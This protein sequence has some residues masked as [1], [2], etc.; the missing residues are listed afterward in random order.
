MLLAAAL[1]SAGLRATS[2]DSWRT[3]PVW[4]DGLSEKCEYEA[5]R[6]IY[7][8]Q[9]VYLAI[10]YSD[11]EVAD[12]RLTVK[13]EKNAGLEVIKHHWSEIIPTE[14]Y[15]YRFSTMSY[16]SAKDLSAFKLTVGTQE[17]CGASFK[18]IW[19]EGDRLRWFESVYFPGAGRREGECE[20]GETAT[21]AD[22]LTLVLRDYPF[23]APRDLKLHVIPSQ[24]DTHRV[25]FDPVARV[26]RH[27]GRSTQE[28]PIGTVEAHEL[29]LL[30][31]EG[32]VEARYW[33]AA[34]AH[35]PMLHVLVRYEG[36]EG[37]TYK[38]KATSRTAYWKH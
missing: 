24:K 1:L 4:Y 34:D 22:A 36:P 38:L 20:K 13:S 21:F 27:A 25:P 26:V 37:I 10:A 28:L 14:N 35:V 3:D 11:K 16:V 6:T 30:T 7:G 32:A 23:D 33:F 29:D 2:S 18:E 8:K 12:P 5:T 9:R 15:D 17:D 31:P 19:R